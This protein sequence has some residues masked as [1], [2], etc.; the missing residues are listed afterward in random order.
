MASV[1]RVPGIAN[2]TLLRPHESDIL[3]VRSLFDAAESSFADRDFLVS[4]Q[5]LTYRQVGDLSR[6][7]AGA[8]ARAG[9]RRGDRV[10][11][12]AAN[13]VDVVLIAIGAFRL[14]A[15]V[16]L[17]HE[18]TTARSLQR[19][20]QQI[21]PVVTVFDRSTIGLRALVPDSTIVA[22]GPDEHLERTVPVQA[23][24]AK[25]DAILPDVLPAPDDPAC[26]VFTSGSAGEPRGVVVSHDNVIFT[27][28]AIQERL[29]YRRSDV[30]GLVVPLSFDYGLYQIFLAANIGA[31]VHVAEPGSV[32]PPLL[33]LLARHEVTILPA[34][35]GLV[36]SV[37]KM[38]DRGTATLPSLR[39]ITSTGD[40]LP[41]THV[42]ALQRAL[43]GVRIFPMYGLTE[44]KR[45]SILL[46]E[47][48]G[49]KP[50]TVGRALAGT[51]VRVVGAN[52]DPVSSGVSGELV[53]GGRNVTLGYWQAPE[54]SERRFRL[55]QLTGERELWTGDICQIDEDGF[56][57]V[58]GRT[59][60]LLKHHGFRISSV[61]IELEACRAPGVIEAAV[62]CSAKGELHLF[63]RW[64]DDRTDSAGLR[65]VL[66]ENLE[67]F[68]VP[69]HVHVVDEMPRTL[70][71]KTARTELEAIAN[72]T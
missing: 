10:L 29:G 67:W 14:G 16:A 66:R 43:P 53:V 56:L 36:A 63:A 48:H 1:S 9:V 27:T 41:T 72:A 33:P 6:A 58:L 55:N 18:G 68:K 62:V 50:G 21:R 22:L 65:R 45:V 32:G 8:L 47:E 26:L 51:T 28:A 39:C 25:R 40:H 15:V 60:T 23:L 59:D 64:T 17:L 2:E 20:A 57:R 3:N 13:H 46:P 7:A 4:D 69:E 30:I 12:A 5:R 42:D 34:I 24:F 44:C 31:S 52:G 71:G 54:E 61:E 11:I 38:L 37:L 35:P 70:N 49:R 19:V